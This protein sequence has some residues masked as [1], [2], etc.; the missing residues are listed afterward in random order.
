[1]ERP[2]FADAEF[3][4]SD[5]EVDDTEMDVLPEKI[6]EQ[7]PLTAEVWTYPVAPW[8]DG[9]HCRCVESFLIRFAISIPLLRQVAP[10]ER[11][12]FYMDTAGLLPYCCVALTSQAPLACQA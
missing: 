9:L 10:M 3:A 2:D 8:A 1:M 11:S 4:D 7:V 6:E 12:S 5:T